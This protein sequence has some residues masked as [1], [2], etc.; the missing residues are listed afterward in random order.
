MTMLSATAR[1]GA[2]PAGAGRA[3]AD[4]FTLSSMASHSRAAVPQPGPLSSLP[5]LLPD[6]ITEFAGKL[7]WLGLD[8]SIAELTDALR[9][10]GSSD[11]LDRVQLRRRLQATMVKRAADIPVFE[12]A[13]DLLLPSLDPAAVTGGAAP[14]G[15]AAGR[16]PGPEDG[17]SA[18]PDLLARLVAMLQGD[19]AAGLSQLASE[20]IGA[21]AGF[22][23]G[24]VAGS[25][26]YY[27]YRIM[28]QL[29]LSAL[30]QQAMR[31][32]AAELAPGLSRQ[33][34]GREQ[35]ERLGELRA[36]I[37]AQLAAHL[38]GLRDVEVSLGE[39]RESILDTELLRA[40]PAELDALR[41]IVAPLARRLASTARRRRRAGRVGGLDMRR[42]MRRAVASGGVPLDPVWRRRHRSRLRLV[43]LCDVSGSVAEF[44]KF[45]LSLLHALH[46]ELPRL[47]SLVF[48]DGVADVTE[49]VV[50]SPGVIDTRLLLSRPGV[51]RGDGHS[52]YGAVLRQ[53]L[54]EQAARLT[55]DCVLII[56]GDARTNHRPERAD[57]LRSLRGRVRAIHWLNPEPAAD[58]DTADSGIGAYAPYCDSVSEVRTLRQLGVW[59]DQLL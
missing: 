21:Y 10:I 11:L 32:D 30:L 57:L 58:W 3:L 42:T 9:A 51:V 6:A 31:L 46:A 52:D 33:L 5:R 26:R 40:T 15:Q 1:A 44:A 29:D 41:A 49:L 18:A 12:A 55:R 43:V 25:Q 53:L 47:R 4:S 8:V 39:L 7:R 28:R 34:A 20:V 48:A 14:Q 59:V 37:A 45:T 36:E 56:C 2:G 50:A 22:Q 19:P 24:Q 23:D 27:E 17:A 35:Q 54:D 38:A 13:F 16:G